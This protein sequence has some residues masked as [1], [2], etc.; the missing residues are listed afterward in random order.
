MNFNHLK[1]P[2]LDFKARYKNI[3]DPINAVTIPIGICTGE[4]KVLARVSLINK[5]I[6]PNTVQYGITRALS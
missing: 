3:G 5:N 1:I 2:F 4:S 6:P